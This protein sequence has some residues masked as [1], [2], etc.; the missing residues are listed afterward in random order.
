MKN[1]WKI[2]CTDSSTIKFNLEIMSFKK[3]LL[4]G[5]RWW[6]VALRSL[7][8]HLVLGFK[9]PACGPLP[10]TLQSHPLLVVNHCIKGGQMLN[11]TLD[12]AFKKKEIQIFFKFLSFF[13][14]LIREFG[15]KYN[16]SSLL[17]GN[18][19]LLDPSESVTAICTLRIFAR[20]NSIHSKS[21]IRKLE[22]LLISVEFL[23]ENSIT[24]DE[25]SSNFWIFQHWKN[26][27][28]FSN[29]FAFT[30]WFLLMKTW[31]TDDNSSCFSTPSVSI[32]FIRCIAST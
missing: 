22:W 25:K 5:S 15:R 10:R 9:L 14:S 27:F 24:N 12:L 11:G 30:L 1:V 16:F 4:C 29:L 17:E 26:S 28:N 3:V 7:S 2:K 13:G 32:S 20:C 21:Y 31:M 23:R 8:Y 18:F 19:S 6:R